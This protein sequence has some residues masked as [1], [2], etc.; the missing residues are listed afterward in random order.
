MLQI[1]AADPAVRRD[2]I[3]ALLCAALPQP[4]AALAYV[5]DGVIL[6][7]G[8]YTAMRRAMILAIFAFRRSRSRSPASTGSACPAAGLP[9][10][11]GWPPA[12][13]CLA[14]AGPG[15]ST[16]STPATPA[17]PS[18]DAGGLRARPPRHPGVLC[19][20]RATLH[21]SRTHLIV[22]E[23]PKM[24][25][26]YVKTKNDRELCEV[27]ETLEDGGSC[28]ADGKR[29]AVSVGVRIVA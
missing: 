8:D 16:S 17:R 10:P 25:G 27:A 7:L 4:L 24:S 23:G 15:L 1:E 26:S 3:V 18:P 28:A 20:C 12:R 9:S 2:A 11:A 6:G 14:G 13:S 29:A 22:S 5:Y 21:S 19:A